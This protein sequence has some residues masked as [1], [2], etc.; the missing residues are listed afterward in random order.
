MNIIK[1]IF[2]VLYKVNYTYY[3]FATWTWEQVRCYW[4]QFRNISDI[5][6][7]WIMEGFIIFGKGPD[8]QMIEI[9]EIGL[10]QTEKSKSHLSSTLSR[11]RVIRPSL[12]RSKFSALCARK[13]LRRLIILRNVKNILLNVDDV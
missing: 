4:P 13:M 7:I 10:L 6:S 12:S 1:Y 11:W 9:I 3:N 2:V 8:S 5:R